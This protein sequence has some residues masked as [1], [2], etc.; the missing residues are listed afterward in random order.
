MDQ[1]IVATW[2][3]AL[4]TW[5]LAVGAIVFYYK[6][7]QIAGQQLKG[8][9]ETIKLGI[10]QTAIS[11]A[12]FEATQREREKS[13]IL[14]V[15]NYAIRPLIPELE[16]MRDY[17]NKI[18]IL[19]PPYNEKARIAWEH[20]RRRFPDYARRISDFNSKIMHMKGTRTSSME[21]RKACTSLINELRD[22][23]VKLTADYNISTDELREIPH[24]R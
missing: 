13:V 7:L 12:Q 10:E 16:E 9:E 5:A 22:L 15:L 17:R 20:F 1:L 21:R 2:V 4:A 8:M 3:L 24:F 19:F 23:V 14:D 11:R 6:Q 18:R